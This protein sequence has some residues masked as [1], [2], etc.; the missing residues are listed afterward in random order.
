MKKLGSNPVLSQTLV[1]VLHQTQGQ[2][3]RIEVVTS[4]QLFLAQLFLLQPHDQ[5][6]MNL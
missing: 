5:M 4:D 1:L 6:T 3:I 2:R